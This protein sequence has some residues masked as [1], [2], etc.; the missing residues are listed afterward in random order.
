ALPARARLRALASTVR[1]LRRHAAGREQRQRSRTRRESAS[2]AP[3]QLHRRELRRQAKRRER[4]LG[5]LGPAPVRTDR[6]TRCARTGAVAS[7]RPAATRLTHSLTRSLIVLDSS[8]SL[9]LPF[10]GGRSLFH[11]LWRSEIPRSGSANP[12]I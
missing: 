12:E 11:S 7:K 5:P 10:T 6:D 3:N 9:E 8:C 4:L 2:G 1:E